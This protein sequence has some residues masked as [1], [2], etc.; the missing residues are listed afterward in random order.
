MC[1]DDEMGVVPDD[2]GVI[3]A[4]A[5]PPDDVVRSGVVVTDDGFGNAVFRSEV[6]DTL[7]VARV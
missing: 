7:F 6:P 5:P 2:A 4:T 1:V 3:V